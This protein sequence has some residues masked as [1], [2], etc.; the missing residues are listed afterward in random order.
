M[1]EGK[2]V[3][4]WAGVGRGREEGKEKGG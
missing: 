3:K 4:G 1:R 2:G